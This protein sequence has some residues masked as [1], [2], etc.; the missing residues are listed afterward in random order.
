MWPPRWLDIKRWIR[1]NVSGHEH[2]NQCFGSGFGLDP[3]PT[4]SGFGLDPDPTG[5]VFNWVGGS[6]GWESGSRQAKKGKN[7]KTYMTVFDQKIYTFFSNFV[8]INLG[9]ILT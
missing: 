4:G 8:I 5:S 6:G 7:L 9:L 3:D 2:S 1:F